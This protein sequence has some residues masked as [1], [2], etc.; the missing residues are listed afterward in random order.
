MPFKAKI[1]GREALIRRLN[2]LV[3]EAEKE[4]AKEQL[5]VAQE[6]ANRVKPRAPGPRSGRYMASIQGDR[7]ANRPGKR[8][9]GRGLKGTTKDKNA[10]GL[11]AEYIWRFLEFGTVKMAARPHI[12]PTWRAY[13]RKARRRMA[14]AVN[15]AVRKVKKG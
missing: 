14:N 6:L 7:L 4:L 12:F 15:K 11:Y 3:P 9:I 8:A 2:R 5:A 10:T 13:K 1:E